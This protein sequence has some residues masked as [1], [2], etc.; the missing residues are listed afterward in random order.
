MELTVIIPIHKI[1]KTEIET[2]KAALQSLVEQTYKDFT[3]TFVISKKVKFS[4]IESVCKEQLQNLNFTYLIKP[5]NKTN[6][7]EMV[8]FGVENVSTPYF[9]ILEFDDKFQTY[10]FE[11]WKKWKSE[12]SSVDVFLPF[13]INL[14]MKNNKEQYAGLQ[15]S[16][17]QAQGVMEKRGY[18]NLDSIKKQKVADLTGGIFKTSNFIDVGKLKENIQHYFNYEL[19]LRLLKHGQ[20]IFVIPKVGILHMN[21]RKNSYSEAFIKGSESGTIDK[22]KWYDIALQEY[23]FRIQ[24]ELN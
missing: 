9:T 22:K 14:Q 19:L 24:R 13:I 23:L 6:Y 2:L 18:L 7:Q 21:F 16:I 1:N 10:W 8:N 15:N 12:L 20:E 3:T 4:D 17:A 11:E 5:D